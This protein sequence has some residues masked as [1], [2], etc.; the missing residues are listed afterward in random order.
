MREP[1]YLDHNA[2]TPILPEA[3]DAMLPYLRG[4]YG[5]PSSQHAHG[6]IARKAVEHAREPV[7]ALIGASPDEILFTS[8]GTEA[9]NLAVRG[10]SEA[11]GA[12]R[13]IVTCNVEHSAIGVVC[14]WLEGR[15]HRVTRVPV[16]PSGRVRAEDV[17]SA[18]EDLTLL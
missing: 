2:T 7:A 14:T 9:N 17:I 18:I 10:A 11:H 8:G 13:H 4:K 1:I 6:Q 16:Q 15:G 3:L 5:N 12:K